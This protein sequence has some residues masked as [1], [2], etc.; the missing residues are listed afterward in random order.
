LS[1][2]RHWLKRSSSFATL[3]CC[4]ASPPSVTAGDVVSAHSGSKQIDLA[5][6]ETAARMLEDG[7]LVAFPTET[8][9]GLGAD[10]ENPN[11]VARIYEAKGRPAD[12]PLIV[13][14]SPQADLDRWASGIPEQARQLA[15]AFWPGPLTMI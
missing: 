6:I 10:A 12:H 2:R 8:V 11:A 14:L 15:Q 13:H 7:R 5:A 4:S 1:L 3:V 9:Y